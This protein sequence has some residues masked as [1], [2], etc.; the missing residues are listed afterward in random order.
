MLSTRKKCTNDFANYSVLG[1]FKDGEYKE[2]CKADKNQK[3]LKIN[4]YTL[5]NSFNDEFIGYSDNRYTLGYG[6][7]KQDILLLRDT[8]LSVL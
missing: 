6:D 3:F 8:S 4:A 2:T 7:T 1:Y 5:Q